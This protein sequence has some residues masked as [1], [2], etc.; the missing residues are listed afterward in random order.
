M[1]FGADMRL[2]VLEGDIPTVM[3][4][5]GDVRRAHGPDEYVPLE[6]LRRVTSALALT[7]LRF[8]G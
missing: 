3:Y 5:P 1:T 2:L 6:D 4:G 8:C 7:I